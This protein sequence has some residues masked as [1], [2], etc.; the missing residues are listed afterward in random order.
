M[1]HD[2]IVAKTDAADTLE[3]LHAS[4]IR[5]TNRRRGLRERL[6]ASTLFA[7]PYFCYLLYL[8]FKGQWLVG[9]IIGGILSI[10]FG[11]HLHHRYVTWHIAKQRQQTTQIEYD[12]ARRAIEAGQLSLISQQ[13]QLTEV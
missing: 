1:T 4:L 13:G 11:L 12:A 9:G 3:D 7:A 6:I 10:F 5:W 8:C 2:P